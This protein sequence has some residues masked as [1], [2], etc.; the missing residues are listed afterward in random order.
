[1]KNNTKY[2][3]AC[4]I[5]AICIIIFNAI[6]DVII[7]P[8]GISFV[9]SYCLSEPLSILETKFKYLGRSF[10]SGLFV[11]IFTS[12]ALSF[13][14]LLIPY[15]FTQLSDLKTLL[16]S[17]IEREILPKL[18]QHLQ[19]IYKSFISKDENI[20]VALLHNS[21]LMKNLLNSS[22]SIVSTISLVLLSPII[23]FY[24]I[25]DWRQ[26]ATS[27]EN[28]LPKSFC[29]DFIQIRTQIRDKI[30]SYFIG[31]IN[32]ILILILFY[33]ILLFFSGIKYGAEIGFL[34]GLFTIIP[35]VGIAFFFL[36]SSC[37]SILFSTNATGSPDWIQL[38]I[39][40]GIF[41]IG[42]ILESG[43]ITPKLIGKKIALHPLW[44]IFGF[45]VCGLLFGFVGILFAIPIT[46][47][48]SVVLS[49][50]FKKYKQFFI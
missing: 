11:L 3:F 2:I 5:I 19:K 43:I 25:R 32:V 20:T 39:I 42:Q 21:S 47:A 26:I 40:I 49:H 30:K 46:V 12:I 13:I 41:I 29:Q 35:Y 16:P 6:K 7:I 48:T 15:I 50:Y 22:I 24:M 28:I 37:V 14:F 9:F 10:F 38:T 18:P 45:L 44:I 1:M 4:I 34:T 8:F 36:L 23:S 27:F 17:S 33:S 31:Q